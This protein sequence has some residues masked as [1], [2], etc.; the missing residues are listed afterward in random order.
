MAL[1]DE[2]EAAQ[3]TRENRRDRLVAATLHRL[4]NPDTEPES[5]PTFKQTASFYLNHLPRL[6]T[7]PEHIQQLRQTILNLAVRG[8]L[9]PQDPGD[10]SAVELLR[11]ISDE[12]ARLVKEKVIRKPQ[13]LPP[14]SEVDFP[15]EMPDGWVLVHLGEIVRVRS[16]NYLPAAKMK[17]GVVPVYGGNGV[18]GYHQKAN[19]NEPTVVIGR[20][21]ALCG[22]V[23]VTPESAWVTDNAFITWFS[24]PNIDLDF[25]VILLRSANLGRDSGATA[26]PVISGRRIYPLVL[27]I[28]PLPEQLRIVAKVNDLMALCSRIESQL[29]S[30]TRTRNGLLE[31]AMQTALA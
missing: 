18:A 15:F 28:P 29:D 14:V 1:C 27:A 5:G 11:R 17:E 4:N 19:V 10:E 13:T 9:V 3:T 2:L 21:G 24:R 7:K 31:A 8:K 6:T 20:V 22:N 26:Q 12:V 16:G 23:H 25:L 30:S